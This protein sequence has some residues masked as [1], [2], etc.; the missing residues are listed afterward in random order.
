V[1]REEEQGPV[2][3]VAIAGE[4]VEEKTAAVARIFLVGCFT[5]QGLMRVRERQRPSRLYI[6]LRGAQAFG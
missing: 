1:E 5:Q 6:A 4:A 3:I 2:V